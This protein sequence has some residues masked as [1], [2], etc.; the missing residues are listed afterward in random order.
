MRFMEKGTFAYA[1]EV[2]GGELGEKGKKV[3][4]GKVIVGE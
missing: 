3:A 4:E 1:I 2:T